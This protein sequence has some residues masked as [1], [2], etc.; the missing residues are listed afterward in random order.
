MAHKASDP[1][2]LSALIFQE[3]SDILNEDIMVLFLE[4][5]ARTLDIDRMNNAYVV[6]IPKE[7]EAT[8][9]SKFRLI[10][11]LNVVYKIV[12]K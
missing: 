12:K 7:E 8:S 11:L 9:V 10:S 3:V 5:Y 2:G 4:L 6:L 1:D